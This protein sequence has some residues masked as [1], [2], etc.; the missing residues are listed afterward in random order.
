MLKIKK[1]LTLFI[2]FFPFFP[3]FVFANTQPRN[4]AGLIKVF[5]DLLN[6]LIPILISLAV[7]AFLTGVAIFILRS[8][9]ETERSK[10]KQFMFWGIIGLFVMTSFWGIVNILEDTFFKK[11]SYGTVI[12]KDQY[13]LPLH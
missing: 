9:N 5:T 11:P 12:E 8:D 13:I 7:L 4:F 2:L 10:G 6:L 1:Y 3:V